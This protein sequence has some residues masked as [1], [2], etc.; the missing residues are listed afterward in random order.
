MLW[1]PVTALELKTYLG[2]VRVS[3]SYLTTGP[4]LTEKISAQ[5]DGD[6]TSI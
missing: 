5:V 1:K 2:A 3:E 4:A 6:W